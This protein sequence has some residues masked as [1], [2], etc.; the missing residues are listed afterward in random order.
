MKTV[1]SDRL[2]SQR[3]GGTS[4]PA[5]CGPCSPLE[6]MI[7]DNT[8]MSPASFSWW[9]LLPNRYQS[10]TSNTAY[11]QRHSLHHR[12]HHLQQQQQPHYHHCI[13]ANICIGTISIITCHQQLQ[14]PCNTSSRTL[15]INNKLR[16]KSDDVSCER[17]AHK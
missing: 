11:Y 10:C 14:P 15:E 8:P 12:Y 17:F 3:A 6:T 4:S 9:T 2:G 5:R 13:L 7:V 16:N 1:Y